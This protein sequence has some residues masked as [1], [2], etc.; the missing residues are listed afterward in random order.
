MSI[1]REKFCLKELKKN[2]FVVDMKS[3]FQDERNV[4]VLTEYLSD[5]SLLDK[6]RGKLGLSK[7]EINFYLSEIILALKSIHDSNIIYRN[8]M[9]ENILFDQNGHVKLIDFGLS[10]KFNDI[11]KS[12][13]YTVWGTPG[14]M[15]PE[16]LLGN[17][18]D[19]KADI[20]AL[21]ITIWEVLGGA[22]PF[23]SSDPV[24]I[25]TKVVHNEYSMPKNLSI[26]MKDLIQKIFVCFPEDRI[27]IP[28][29]MAHPAFATIN[30]KKVIS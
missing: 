21:G 2:N 6:I 12:R 7:K 17:G 8:L 30:W 3:H 18:Y 22:I 5:Q 20:W 13:T 25:H 16:V 15:S 27:S 26:T 4:Y 11:Q 10:K 24:K 23:Y 29:I 9:P 14:Y 28:E 1:R 19:Y